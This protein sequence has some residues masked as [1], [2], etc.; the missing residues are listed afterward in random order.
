[1]E[2][3]WHWYRFNHRGTYL[4]VCDNVSAL[5][6]LL[7]ALM[8]STCG[9]RTRPFPSLFDDLFDIF[10]SSSV[11]RLGDFWKLILSRFLLKF[12]QID[13]DFLGSSKTSTL[14]VK[15]TVATFGKVWATFNLNIW[16]H[17]SRVF[18]LSSP[19]HSIE[20]RKNNVTRLSPFISFRESI[21]NFVQREGTLF[22]S[23]LITSLC[24]TNYGLV[25]PT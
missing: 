22:L 13:G 9:Q 10:L 14:Q 7:S 12:A 17:C 3:G 21:Q 6:N 4:Y 20:R 16:S 23:N 5:M 2:I 25:D 18:F 15:T 11:T 19:E 8:L 24:V 1:M